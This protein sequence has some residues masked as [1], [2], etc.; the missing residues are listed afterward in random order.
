MNKTAVFSQMNQIV[1][2][3]IECANKYF[4]K[5]IFTGCKLKPLSKKHYY[6]MGVMSR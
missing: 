3:P 1:L 5:E 2:V 4:E 6:G